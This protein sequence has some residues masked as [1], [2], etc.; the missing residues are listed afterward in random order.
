[1]GNAPT[2]APTK[3]LTT[4]FT[5]TATTTMEAHLL[6]VQKLQEM[7]KTL[8]EVW[9]RSYCTSHQVTKKSFCLSKCNDPA[10]SC[11]FY[12]NLHCSV[13]SCACRPKRRLTAE[14][15]DEETIVV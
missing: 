6:L 14:A 1:M 4:L 3:A 11:L 12:C 2:N 13:G 7:Q 9:K 8:D 10:T 5:T 15:S